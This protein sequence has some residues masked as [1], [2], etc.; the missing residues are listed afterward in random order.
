MFQSPSPGE[1]DGGLDYRR[2]TLSNLSEVKP[3]HPGDLTVGVWGVE[4]DHDAHWT[5]HSD[6]KKREVKKPDF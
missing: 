1:H 5:A 2:L 4:D 3:I 6:Q